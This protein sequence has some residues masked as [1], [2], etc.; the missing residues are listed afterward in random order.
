MRSCAI[1][2]AVEL[3]YKEF[4]R[5][6]RAR[7]KELKLTQS[8]LADRVG[9]T[10]TSITNIEA[11]RQHVVLHQLFLLASEIAVKP[12]DL[13]PREETTLEEL[14]STP[15]TL[16]A[17][18]SSRNPQDQEAITKLLNTARTS[19]RRENPAA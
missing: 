1:I 5:R 10:R 13:L 8:Q 16:K 12:E 6:L 14:V 18:R 15:E 17:I 4:G 2:L 7:R 9:L 3:L 19:E 11:G